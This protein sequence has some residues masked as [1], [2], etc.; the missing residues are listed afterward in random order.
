VSN[1]WFGAWHKHRYNIRIHSCPFVVT[2][3]RWLRQL[4]GE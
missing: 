2:L 1:A 3:R 4:I